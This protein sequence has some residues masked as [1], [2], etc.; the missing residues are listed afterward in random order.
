MQSWDS[1]VDIGAGYGLHGR[2]LIPGRD[3]KCFSVPRRQGQLLCSPSLLISGHQG[4]FPIKRPWHEA[5]LHLEPE[6]R[7]V[8][9]HL[10][11][12]YVFMTQCLIN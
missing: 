8:E 12:L 9:L 10:H 7:T 11:S 3:K 4:N 2:D 5:D 6:S 1:S